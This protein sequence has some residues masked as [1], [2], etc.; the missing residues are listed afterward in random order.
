MVAFYNMSRVRRLEYRSSTAGGLLDELLGSNRGE[1]EFARLVERKRSK[2]KS[3]FEKLLDKP[4][5]K[6]RVEGV[7]RI[8]P[9]RQSAEQRARARSAWNRAVR[10]AARWAWA[11][12]RRATPWGRALDVAQLLLDYWWNMPGV[13]GVSGYAP[14]TPLPNPDGSI[15]FTP[16]RFWSN[17]APATDPPYPD[18]FNHFMDSIGS[19][20]LGQSHTIPPPFN[21]TNHRMI[22]ANV[23][24]TASVLSPYV[25]WAS[26]YFPPVPGSDDPL[27]R[28]R[29]VPEEFVPAPEGLERVRVR[30]AYR[31]LQEPKVREKMSPW[32]P[33]VGGYIARTGVFTPS[34]AG[35][36]RTPERKLRLYGKSYR[37][38]VSIAN[39]LGGF[40]ELIDMLADAAGWE[41]VRELGGTP[42]YNKAVWLF[43][44]GG[45]D[46]VDWERLMD[47]DRY[48]EVEDFAYGGIGSGSAGASEALGVNP[49]FQTGPAL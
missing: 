48:N 49:G 18:P 12:G 35:R 34:S 8:P 31:Y 24:R 42:V 7:T 9:T 13:T 15:T 6:P 1:R 5:T 14:G 47:L 37:T 4:R 22:Y 20:F 43:F 38:L 23:T 27:R 32:G 45:I 11:S 39:G 40:I 2:P 10:A 36:P 21:R 19:T 29:V 33:R 25:Y 30:R 41:Y 16:A 46:L 3:E 44:L 17:G 28:A 26:H